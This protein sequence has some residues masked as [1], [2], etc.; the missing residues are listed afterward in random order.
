MKSANEA[1]R[2][3]INYLHER[4]RESAQQDCHVTLMTR[5]IE[6]SHRRSKWTVIIIHVIRYLPEKLIVVE[7]AKKCSTFY[8]ASMFVIFARKTREHASNLL[9]QK[10]GEKQKP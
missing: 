10:C 4:E 8:A 3:S 9:P 5:T 7:L 6:G 1:R 2:E